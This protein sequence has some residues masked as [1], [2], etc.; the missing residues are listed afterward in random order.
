SGCQYLRFVD[1]VD[2]YGLQDL[3]LHKMAYATFRH[4]RDSDRLF[5]LN[6][7]F[8]ITHASNAAMSANIG[9]HTLQCHYR[10]GSCLLCNLRLIRGNDI[11]DNPSLEHLWK[12][13]FNLYCS[14]LLLHV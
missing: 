2:S 14:C 7:Q 6:D 13:A 4:Y 8:G 3:S 1:T 10:R 5:N 12:T 9:W 11:A